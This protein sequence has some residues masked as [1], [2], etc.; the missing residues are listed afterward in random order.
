MERRLVVVRATKRCCAVGLLDKLL[1]HSK[2]S[3]A[4]VAKQ[5]ARVVTIHKR[6]ISYPIPLAGFLSK[7]QLSDGRAFFSL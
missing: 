7:L 5:K 2:T 4:A 1:S 6:V 3:H